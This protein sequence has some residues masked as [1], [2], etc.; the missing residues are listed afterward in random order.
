MEETRLI[1]LND[2]K[3]DLVGRIQL[4]D[5]DLADNLVHQGLKEPLR[6]QGP[7]SDGKYII[8]S[9]IRRFEAM[10]KKP[11]QFITVL[12]RVSEVVTSRADR[13]TEMLT[14]TMHQKRKTKFEKQLL[15]KEALDN[16]MTKKELSKK[17]N[18]PISVI[19]RESKGMEIPEKF[20]RE[21]AEAKGSQ[22]ALITIFKLDC[23]KSYRNV[24]YK[25]L[26]NR[27]IGT[28]DS[29]AL[30]KIIKH[31]EY[32][33]LDNKQKKKVIEETLSNCRFKYEDA[34]QIIMLELLKDNPENHSDYVNEWV[35][36]VCDDIERLSGMIN[37]NMNKMVSPFQKKR[38]KAALS[39]LRKSLK[40]VYGERKGNGYKID[41]HDEEDD[42]DYQRNV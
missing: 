5:T 15:I 40:W 10:K 34:N 23:D 4:G 1:P 35:N 8:I 21:V 16:G 18:K 3:V 38:I 30:N 2:L 20:R 6:V 36:C 11:G 25:R 33:F 28:E 7:D 9:G 24:L 32:P 13:A 26:L 39:K 29:R 31:S 12:C 22:D 41:F 37:P 19:N 42:D 27:E 17:I 14:D